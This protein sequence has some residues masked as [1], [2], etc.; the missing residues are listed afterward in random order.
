VSDGSGFISRPTG[1][2]TH[3]LR[4]VT[5]RSRARPRSDPDRDDPIDQVS[6]VPE[7]SANAALATPGTTALAPHHRLRPSAPTLRPRT[8]HSGRWHGDR[9]IRE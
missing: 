3:S 5:K 8:L 7:V 2:V 9:L 1:P 6:G 4:P